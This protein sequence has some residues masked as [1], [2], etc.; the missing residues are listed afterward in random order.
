METN[1]QQNQQKNANMSYGG[2]TSSTSP[3]PYGGL[4]FGNNSFGSK[5]ADTN[6]SAAVD[7]S[8]PLREVPLF[9]SVRIRVGM[10]II[11]T[12]MHT[13]QQCPTSVLAQLFSPPFPLYDDLE[14]IHRY[15]HEY[16]SEEPF[17]QII[18]CL[19]SGEWV[20]C[21]ATHEREELLRAV[22]T[23]SLEGLPDV[24]LAADHNVAISEGGTALFYHQAV[25]T[26]NLK[27][28]K[29]NMREREEQL[30]KFN[31]KKIEVAKAKKA[32]DAAE[33][34]YSKV[35]AV[36][37]Q[38][39]GAA[40]EAR[41]KM[42]EFEA[43]KKN[44]GERLE[45]ARKKFVQ[46][47]Q[48]GKPLMDENDEVQRAA[49]KAK[50]AHVQQMEL[51]EAAEAA[52]KAAEQ[53]QPNGA[54]PIKDEI[55][56]E[57]AQ[58]ARE[59]TE[60]AKKLADEKAA[61]AAEFSTRVESVAKEIA[62]AKSEI[63]QAQREKEELDSVVRS[64]GGSN[65]NGNS[66]STN[67]TL[68]TTEQIEERNKLAD[69]AEEGARP[70]RE[71]RDQLLAAYDDLVKT[72]ESLKPKA[73]EEE[74]AAKR[75][76]QEL[77]EENIFIEEPHPESIVPFGTPRIIPRQVRKLGLK[78]Y[79]VRGEFRGD[80]EVNPPPPARLPLTLF[81]GADAAAGA[82]GGGG[83]SHRLGG[84]FGGF[85]GN[86]AVRRGGFGHRTIG[87][88][89]ATTGTQKSTTR[90]SSNDTRVASPSQQQ[91]P[92]LQPHAGS[93][94]IGNYYNNTI[95]NNNQSAAAY[96]QSEVSTTNQVDP[97]NRN[98]VVVPFSGIR[99]QSFCDTTTVMM[100]KELER[101]DFLMMLAYESPNGGDFFRQKKPV[102]ALQELIDS[103]TL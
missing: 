14:E 85:G 37:L 36:A 39:R 71:K 90:T 76:Q 68:Y 57:A 38:Y 67:I 98:S 24:P 21:R 17:L 4:N 62:A 30:Q 33:D 54:D 70:L 19:R 92:Q 55:L 82:A 42:D 66:N 84:G 41:R 95:N 87:G 61:I 27:E 80:I 63:E 23:L 69:E 64:T 44:V 100:E 79:Q 65:Y 59:L 3:S 103:C 52:A 58:K 46:T 91:Q 13:L 47:E 86:P 34:S 26:E 93:N 74:D 29:K 16:V 51:T 9:Q 18:D 50:F 10:K 78:G 7:D 97:A 75:R 96:N 102:G 94:N 48:D 32:L 73:P 25:G 40:D 53:P 20:P 12:T 72:C 31:Q 99:G 2:Y 77:L 15:P 83:V 101:L 22:A 89:G 88:G 45:A 43:R 6:A 56:E 35:H 81:F 1:N 28:L 5:P 11:S 60:H 49:R 8:S